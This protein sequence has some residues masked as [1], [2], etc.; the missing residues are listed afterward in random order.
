MK[1]IKVA[2]NAVRV[3]KKAGSG[4]DTYI[5]NLVNE[6]GRT[7][8]QR[9]T[10]DHQPSTNIEFDVYTLYPQHFP[11]V[12]PQNIKQIKILPQIAQILKPRI[13]HRATQVVADKNDEIVE[14]EPKNTCYPTLKCPGSRYLNPGRASVLS[15]LKRRLLYTL[16]DWFRIFW[17]QLV[18][19]FYVRKYDVVVAMTQLDGVVFCPTKQIIFIY[20]LIPYVFPEQRHKHKFFLANLLPLMVRSAT[21]IIA[22][23][24]NTKDD[25]VKFLNIE[26]EKIAIVYAANKYREIPEINENKKNE[27]KQKYELNRY[28]LFVGSTQPHKNLLSLI[29]AFYLI[30]K[31]VQDIDLVVVGYIERKDITKINSKLRTLDV[32]QSVKF[33]GHLLDNEISIVYSSAEL[34][35]FPTLYE[36]FGLPPLEAMALGCP[37]VVS[38]TSSLPE[39]VGD[40]G[41]YVD[42]Y[43]PQDIADGILKVLT[44]DSLRQ[45]LIKKGFEQIKKF[46]WEK[47]A[48]ETLKVF[49][50]VA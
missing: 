27:F 19:P 25:I 11:D 12:P 2:L 33:L 38:N 41:V 36:G 24:K 43:S 34:F 26:P 14:Q 44:D 49:E 22:I 6:L 4:F 8:Y 7:C 45:S 46:S 42:P 21:K 50:E 1:T 32:R 39:V 29:D 48:K 17:T 47:S 13:N 20:D 40:A 3:T 31:R 30:R 9:S 16:A 5:I 35:V 23:S 28:I 10:I 37:V 15:A 18:F